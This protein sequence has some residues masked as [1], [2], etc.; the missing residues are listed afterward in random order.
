MKRTVVAF[1]VLCAVIAAPCAAQLAIPLHVVPVVAK[2]GGIAGT[3]WMTSVSIANASDGTVDVVAWFLRENQ[4]NIPPLVP[5]RTLVLTAGQ[6]TTVDDVLGTWFPG[7]GDTKGVL[8]I[9]GELRGAGDEDY[10]KLAVTSRIFNNA[11]PA[12]TYGQGV[13]SGLL[14]VMAAPGR[15]VLAGARHD[16]AV[17]SNIGIVNISTTATSFIVT[18][19]A[20]NGAVTSTATLTVPAFSLVQRNLAQLGTPSMTAPGRVEVVVDPA[21]VTW[22]P[23]DPEISLDGDGAGFIAYLSKVDQA[24]SDAEFHPGQSDWKAYT[25]LCGDPPLP[26]ATGLPGWAD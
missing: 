4:T 9:I 17:R 20:A 16:D 10:A 1:F 13:V 12:A 21:T 15:L 7:Q 24:T 14:N 23:C 6:T 8:V 18:T 25:D 26:V 2:T 22:D 11:T 5:T 3:D 19:S